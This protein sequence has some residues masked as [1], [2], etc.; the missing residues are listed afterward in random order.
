MDTNTETKQ[1][2]LG[3]LWKRQSRAG[4]KYLAGTVDGKKVVIF[5]NDHKSAD[6]QPDFRVF[7]AREKAQQ[8]ESETASAATDGGEDLL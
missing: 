4:Q 2:E 3:A 1:Q 8:P 7:P 6:N 5:T